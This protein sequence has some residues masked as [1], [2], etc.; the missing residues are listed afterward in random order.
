MQIYFR[1]SGV[2]VTLAYNVWRLYAV[3][4]YIQVMHL[5]ANPQ[6]MERSCCYAFVVLFGRLVG[7]LLCG[8]E[9]LVFV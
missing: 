7:S 9:E 2:F 4:C 6:K 8:C 5:S 1:E 3:F